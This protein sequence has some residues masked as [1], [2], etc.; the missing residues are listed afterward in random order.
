ME[1]I[2]SHQTAMLPV[3]PI[4][5]YSAMTSIS[6]SLAKF[7]VIEENRASNITMLKKLEGA[8]EVMSCCGRKAAKVNKQIAHRAH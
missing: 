5:W 8:G 7:K 1:F 4:T 6:M 3:T 2:I